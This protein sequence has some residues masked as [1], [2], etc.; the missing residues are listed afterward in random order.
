MDEGVVQDR[1]ES[2]GRGTQV[3]GGRKRRGTRESEMLSLQF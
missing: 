3:G 1:E 2:G